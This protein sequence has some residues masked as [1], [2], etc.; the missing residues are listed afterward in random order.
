MVSQSQQICAPLHSFL[1]AML[2]LLLALAAAVGFT[3]AKPIPANGQ[4]QQ[5]G[6]AAA[7]HSSGPG[8]APTASG[9][10]GIDEEVC[11]PAFCLHYINWFLPIQKWVQKNETMKIK[12]IGKKEH[13]FNVRFLSSTMTMTTRALCPR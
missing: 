10:I 4:Q 2:L 6:S 12:K 5:H 13:L 7:A 11:L 9:G 8:P 3:E 1:F